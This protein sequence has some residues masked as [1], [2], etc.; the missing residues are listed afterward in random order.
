[1]FLFLHSFSA[2]R[3]DAVRTISKICCK[4]DIKKGSSTHWIQSFKFNGIEKM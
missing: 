2:Y 3:I 4:C 1:M